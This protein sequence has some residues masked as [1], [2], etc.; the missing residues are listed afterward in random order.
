MT[1]KEDL[2]SLRQKIDVITLEMTRLFLART[3]VASRIGRL[4]MEIGKD[5][6][7]EARETELRERVSELCRYEAPTADEA[8]DGVQEAG[9]T[10]AVKFLDFL[11]GE[12][13]RVQQQQQQKKPAPPTHLSIF[14][15][16]KE[17]EE[18]GRQII[19]MEVGEPDF[20]PPRGVRRA[21]ADACDRGRVRY[22]PAKGIPKLRQAIATHASERF[23]TALSAENILVSPGAR[24]AVFAAV[25]MLLKPADEMIV[26][27]PAWP[28]YRD[29]AV[30]AG[31]TVKALHTTLEG[32][33]TPSPKEIAG[34]VTARTRMIVLNYPNNP[35]GKVLEPG[36]MDDIVGIASDNGLYVLSDEIYSEYSSLDWRSLLSYG[37]ERGVTVQSFSKSHAMTGLRIGYAAAEPGII[38][39]MSRLAALCL[40]SVPE[41]VQYAALAALDEDVSGNADVMAER[42]SVLGREAR[43]LGLEFVPPD[44]GMYVFGRMRR[45]GFDG[46]AFAESALERGVAVAPGAAFGPYHDFVRISACRDTKTLIEGMYRL[47]NMLEEGNTT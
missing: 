3:E 14:L 44:G 7:D 5:V 16:A 12:S 19:H 1:P 18:A 15:R 34:L 41:P 28:A 9:R 17:L 45:G 10:G 30:H 26:I 11:I 33:W 2:E 8:A 4:K 13:I 42:L 37:Y 23:G 43:V 21:L 40:T 35:T 47:K 6:T 39:H 38:G 32:G 25:S 29:C 31:V 27:E 46:A 36:V 22:A 20:V 24:F